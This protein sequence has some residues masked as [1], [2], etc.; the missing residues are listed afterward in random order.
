MTLD[1]VNTAAN[2]STPLLLAG[3]LLYLR[4]IFDWAS[5][6]ENNVESYR[7]DMRRYSRDQVR[8][9][10]ATDPDLVQE[11]FGQIGGVN[12]VGAG[13]QG[14]HQGRQDHPVVQVSHS[15]NGVGS[16]GR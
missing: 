16:V 11:L 8:A 2:V 7:Q 5:R 1:A 14:Q 10:L 4:R 13:H 12:D 15:G 3:T 6:D 9:V